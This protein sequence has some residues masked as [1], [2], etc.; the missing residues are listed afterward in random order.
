[1]TSEALGLPAAQR[2]P[3]AP[4]RRQPGRGAQPHRSSR[5]HHAWR[6]VQAL[7]AA[8]RAGCPHPAG[9]GHRHGAPSTCSTASVTPAAASCAALALTDSPAR[10]VPSATKL[11]TAADSSSRGESSQATLRGRQHTEPPASRQA[12]EA[13]VQGS[14]L[15]GLPGVCAAAG[16]AKTQEGVPR[17]RCAAGERCRGAHRPLSA[18][19]SRS[20]QSSSGRPPRRSRRSLR[21]ATR[22]QPQLPGGE[23]MARKNGVRV[24]EHCHGLPA[25][26]AQA[27]RGLCC[28][29]AK[30]CRRRG[31]PCQLASPVR[32]A[33][34]LPARRH[35]AASRIPPRQCA[36]ALRQQA[37]PPLALGTCARRTHAARS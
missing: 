10:A 12:H 8:P 9:R 33:E 4:A 14:L 1:M 24:K 32:S 17:P 28:G 15:K 37:P 34:Y 5:R 7:P 13:A 25:A 20:A 19:C 11:R 6:P 36:Q 22:V 16:R 29:A 30:A 3:R 18:G 31:P 2:R 26:Y 23:G 27:R 21:T 35:A